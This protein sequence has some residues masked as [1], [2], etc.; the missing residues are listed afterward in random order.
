[1]VFPLEH[2]SIYKAFISPASGTFAWVGAES[3]EV[4]FL[5]DFRWSEK[6]MPWTD[7]LNLLEGAPVHISAP[8]THFAEDIL[9]SKDTP[10]FSTSD[11]IIRKYECGKINES[12]TDTM[13]ARWVDFKFNNQISEPKEIPVCTKCFAEF[14]LET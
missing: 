2:T 4:V 13:S 8:K 12:E 3:S 9:W 11:A 6:I 1:M 7:L 5:N 10:I 14:V